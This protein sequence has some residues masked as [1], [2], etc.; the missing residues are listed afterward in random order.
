MYRAIIFLTIILFSAFQ[1]NAQENKNM[2]SADEITAYKEQSK[3]MISY[4]EGTLNFLGDPQEVIAEKEIIINDSYKKIFR[5]AEVQIEDDLDENREV[6]LRKNVQAYL[7]DIVFFYKQVQFIYTVSSVEQIVG[8]N[9]DIVFKVTVNRALSGITVNN[10]TVNNNQLRYIEINLDP[11]KKDLRIVSIYSTK[12]NAKEEMRYW[13]NML[14]EAWRNYFGTKVLVFDTLPMN[15]I[16][17][18]GDSLVVVLKKQPVVE[19]DSL[20]ISNGDTLRFIR[21][22]E[23]DSGSYQ[24]VYNHDTVFKDFNDTV[25]ANVAGL[26]SY[27][28]TFFN[29][30]AIN[31]SNN[32]LIKTLAPLARLT[33]LEKIEASN[34][35][36]DDIT[37]LRNLNKLQELNLSG[38]PVKTIEPLMFAFNLKVL[39]ISGTEV[40]TLDGLSGLTQLES[41]VIDSTTLTGLSPLSAMVNLSYLS[42]AYTPV[43]N[44]DVIGKLPA[45]KK[46]N[47]EGSSVSSLKPLSGMSALENINLD[48]TGVSDLSPLASDSSLRI[49]QAN[50]TAVSSLDGLLNNANLKLIYCDNSGIKKEEALSFMEQ[51][52]GCLVIFDSKRLISWWN[53]IPESWK[54]ALSKGMILSDPP[55]KEEL[56]KI[57]NTKKLVL[58]NNAAIDNLEPLKMLFKLESLDISNTP[59]N[60]LSPLATTGNLKYLNLDN[61]LDSTLNS[62]KELTNLVEIHFENTSIS[63]LEPLYNNKNLEVVY[64]DSTGV[65]TQQVLALKSVIP[66]CLVIYQTGDLN[67]WW[68]N[69]PDAWQEVLSSQIE[70]DGTP[71]REQL[72]QMVDLTTVSIRKNGEIND[73]EPLSRFHLLKKL[74]ITFTAIND[75]SPLSVCDSLTVLQL[76][77]NPVE[78][79]EPLA[80]LTLLREINLENTSVEDISPLV[81][82]INLEKLNLSGTKVKKLKPLSKLDS[83]QELV[84][85]N[86]RVNRL[87]DIAKLPELKKLVCYNTSIKQKKVAAFKADHPDCEV[88]YY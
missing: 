87:T 85:N 11:L 54:T 49:I 52:P 63:N 36:I 61:T 30:N 80:N 45:L 44:L 75:L 55:T 79:L 2:L 31:I 20:L 48:K 82:L 83:L 62:L 38:T 10:D 88:I 27:L 32:H 9:G 66:Q 37:P 7:K 47:I 39:D 19:T 60:D 5:D 41:L 50:N 4:L 24:I 21:L 78:E 3:M 74:T 77:N 46:L 68:S 13:W 57:V 25:K 16:A 8:E 26:D 42:L 40:S 33:K 18:F 6:P 70:I 71:S 17:S 14:P 84:I 1:V 53:N 59:V 58:A 81:G 29:T 28:R 51:H 15:R 12:P 65:S 73:L 23:L 35:F 34:V 72:Q 76:P 67:F 22:P 86:T 64:C 69:L 56:Q 43:A